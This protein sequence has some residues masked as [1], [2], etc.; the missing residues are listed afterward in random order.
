MYCLPVVVTSLVAA[1]TF[2]S[3][4][5]QDEVP[6]RA[7]DIK[8]VKVG[9][10]VPVATL[11]TLKGIRTSLADVI[12]GKPSVIIFYRGG[13]CPYCNVHLAELAKVEAEVKAK[14]YQLVA[15]SPDTPEEL[16]KTIGKG[17]LTYTLLSDSSADAMKKFG[18]AFRVDDETFKMYRDRFKIDLEKASGQTHHY[19]PVPAVFAVKGGVINFVYTN[20]DY[21]VRLKGAD[22]IK[23]LNTD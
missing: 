5:S 7:E 2:A 8:P 18:I 6:N 17:K 9:A 1:G 4:L 11:S 21:K 23:A 12:G 14:G 22:L 15:I 19:L 16:N 20:P 13:W 3:R 10:K